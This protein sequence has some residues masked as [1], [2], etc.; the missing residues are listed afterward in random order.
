M[1][2][3]ARLLPGYEVGQHTLKGGIEVSSDYHVVCVTGPPL[4][5]AVDKRK[6]CSLLLRLASLILIRPQTDSW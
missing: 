3:D 5:Y 6:Q 2:Q 4:Y 1:W